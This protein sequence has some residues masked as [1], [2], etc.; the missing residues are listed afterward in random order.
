VVLV[1]RTRETPALGGTVVGASIASILSVVLII[2]DRMDIRSY[3][4][5]DLVSEGQR[6]TTLKIIIAPS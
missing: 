2:P 1:C 4:A 6:F 5:E 3:C